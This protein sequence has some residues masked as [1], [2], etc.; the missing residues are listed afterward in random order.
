VR[1]A[2][3][4]AWLRRPAPV[5]ARKTLRALSAATRDPDALA[6]LLEAVKGLPW[7][8]KNRKA[9]PPH[10]EEKLRV[11]DHGSGP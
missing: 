2:L 1:N 9:L 3:W 5:A 8:L 11:L 7:A 6:G 10:V 4:F